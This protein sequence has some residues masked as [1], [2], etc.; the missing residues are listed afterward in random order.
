[1]AWKTLLYK[2]LEKHHVKETQHFTEK[3]NFTISQP[4]L[5]K[6]NA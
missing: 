2:H 6:T 5:N 4:R 3:N 1:M